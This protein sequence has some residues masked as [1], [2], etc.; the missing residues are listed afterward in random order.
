MFRLEWMIGL[1][2]LVGKPGSERFFVPALE[3]G[4]NFCVAVHSVGMDTETKANLYKPTVALID[5]G[6][7]R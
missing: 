3:S 7:R 5:L 6:L 1:P 4:L 2:L